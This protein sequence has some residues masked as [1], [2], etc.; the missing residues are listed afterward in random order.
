MLQ[1]YARIDR[2][3][4]NYHINAESLNLTIKRTKIALKLIHFDSLQ[5][6]YFHE[7]MANINLNFLSL[8]L[9]ISNAAKSFSR[10]KMR[11]YFISYI[12]SR[13]NHSIY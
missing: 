8:P 10:K 7:K 9:G 2:E 5:N 1:K 3:Y 12:F 6:H 4:Y 13:K 11:V